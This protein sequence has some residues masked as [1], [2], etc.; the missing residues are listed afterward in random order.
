MSTEVSHVKTHRFEID[1]EGQISYL[2]YEVDPQGWLVLW[3]TEVPATLR[4]RGLAGRLV[5]KAFKYAEEHRLKVEV[6]CPFAVGFVTRH[7]ELQKLVSKR[8]NGIR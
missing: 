1:C 3:H 6:I 8:P 5:R 7:P 4:G 2:A